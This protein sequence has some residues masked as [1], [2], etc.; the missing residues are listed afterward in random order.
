MITRSISEY[1]LNTDAIF[2][3]VAVDN[4]YGAFESIS[5]ILHQLLHATVEGLKEGGQASLKGLPNGV[6]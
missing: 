5:R 3:M 1:F 6:A 2:S 4:P